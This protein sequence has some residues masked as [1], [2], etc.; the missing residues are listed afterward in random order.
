MSRDIKK[1]TLDR[2]YKYLA[3]KYNDALFFAEGYRHWFVWLIVEYLEIKEDDN[4]ADLGGGTGIFAKM[5]HEKAHLKEDILCVD[6]CEEMLKGAVKLSGVSTLCTDALSF[7]QRK[8]VRYNKILIKEAVHHFD[9]RIS[10]WKGIYNQL[11][12]AGKLLIIT[13]PPRPDFP[14]FKAA[15]NTFEQCQP[16][17]NILSTELENAGFRVKVQIRPYFL[18][19]DKTCWFEKIRQRFMSNLTN[20]N[21]EELEQGLRELEEKY[22]AKETL[23]FADRLVFI[24]GTK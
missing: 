4:V 22:K 21:D 12:L 18:K 9:D 19:L 24:V 10:K 7:S 3:E 1:Q 2:H 17:Y 11:C 23:D 16:H 13:R 5:V 14:L 15:L 6:P 8:D 20:F